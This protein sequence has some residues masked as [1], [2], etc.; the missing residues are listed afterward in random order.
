MRTKKMGRNN[1]FPDSMGVDLG[2]VGLRQ[3][4]V[5]VMVKKRKG[6][7]G[8]GRRSKTRTKNLSPKKSKKKKGSSKKGRKK[9]KRG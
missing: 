8:T 1:E 3:V 2:R 7:M 4:T 5:T 6:W 9:K